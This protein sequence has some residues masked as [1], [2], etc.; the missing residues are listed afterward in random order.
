M[1][2]LPIY[3]I[4]AECK[5]YV[6]PV[7]LKQFSCISELNMCTYQIKIFLG[8]H[9]WS[10]GFLSATPVCVCSL[11]LGDTCF[12]L[13]YQNPN[14]VQPEPNYSGVCKSIIIVATRNKIVSVYLWPLSL[15]CCTSA[16][17]QHTKAGFKLWLHNSSE[18]SISCKIHFLENNVSRAC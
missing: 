3:F 8:W 10:K 5:S 4:I 13:T 11:C 14:M 16:K 9:W 12:L 18:G 7:L 17:Y 1:L 6:H 15:P 2:L